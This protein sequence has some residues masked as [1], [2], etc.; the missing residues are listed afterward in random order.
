MT[1]RNA[2]PRA[3]DPFSVFGR[4]GTPEDMSGLDRDIEAVADRLIGGDTD[5]R[6]ED[7]RYLGY[8]LAVYR[9]RRGMVLTEDHLRL[10]AAALGIERMSLRAAEKVGLPPVRDHEKFLAAADA[11]AAQPDV[12]DYAL[13]RIAGVDRGTIRRWRE[14]RAFWRRV[15]IARFLAGERTDRDRAHA[16]M[17]A[18]AFDRA[19]KRR[20]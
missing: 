18:K 10:L 2:S 11:V 8:A 3:P 5:L 17:W 19:R 13:A 1:R 6:P 12:S 9:T 16:A 4:T 20:E 14:L 7:V 15:R